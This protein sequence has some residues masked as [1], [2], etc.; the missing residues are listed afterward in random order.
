[1]TYLSVVIPAYNERKRLPKTLDKVAAFLA[2][3]SYASEIVVVNDGSTDGLGDYLAQRQQ[4][5]ANLRVVTHPKNKGK[6]LSVKDGMLAAEGTYRLFMD[7]DGSTSIDQVKKLLKAMPEC[8]IAIGS[9]HLEKGSIK[10]S[11]TLQRRILSRGSN[12]LIRTFAVPGIRDTQC[13]FKLFTAEATEKVFPRQSESRWLFD[14][15]LLV[16]ARAQGLKVR[17]VA[18]DWYDDENSTMRAGRA[19]A[20]SLRDLWRIMQR[21]RA[22]AYA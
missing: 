21:R 6:G 7:A 11:R 8:D 4:E 15:E 2:K 13:G 1:M 5:I 12:W 9:R 22:G 3:Q 20:R 10:T 18:V 19:A 14:V 17:E 16:I